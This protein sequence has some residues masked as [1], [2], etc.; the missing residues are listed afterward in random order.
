MAN[1][2]ASL[3]VRL[4]STS[5]ESI[6]RAAALRHVSMSDYVRSVVVAQAQ[7]ELQAAEQRIIALTPEEQIA[8]WQALN[9]PTP[10]TEAQQALGAL[11]R[12]E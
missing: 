3:M 11:I 12:G 10:L 7:R 9:E 2:S 8:F 6:A 5:K 4:D 1:P